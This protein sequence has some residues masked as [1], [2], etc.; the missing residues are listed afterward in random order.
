M[1]RGNRPSN[2]KIRRYRSRVL[3]RAEKGQYKNVIK[4]AWMY[5]DY[6]NRDDVIGY[7]QVGEHF[8]VTKATISI[9]LRFLTLPERFVEWLGRETNPVVLA[10]FG[11]KLLKTI[12]RLDKSEHKNKL[13]EELDKVKEEIVK[14]KL[15]IASV[16]GIL[17]KLHS[18]GRRPRDS[19][20]IEI[21]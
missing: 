12:S 11:M 1:K 3:T 2:I 13:V 21:A 8:S 19:R 20:A 18:N 16:E 5:R 15:P 4:I 17:R 14:V 10:H 6:L 9:Y 7:R